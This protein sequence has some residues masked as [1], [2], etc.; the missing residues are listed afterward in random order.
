MN[1]ILEVGEIF[2]HFEMSLICLLTVF[3]Q[4]QSETE[5]NT[6]PQ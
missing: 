2:W 5:F 6:T 3:T 1:K 4:I